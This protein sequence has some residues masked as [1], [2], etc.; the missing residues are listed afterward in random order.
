MPK[1]GRTGQETPSQ[2]TTL[3]RCRSPGAVRPVYTV[4]N[5]PFKPINKLDCSLPA[6]AEPPP[7]SLAQQAM[8]EGQAELSD[9]QG[10][11]LCSACDHHQLRSVLLPLQSRFSGLCPPRQ[12]LCRSI[13][14]PLQADKQPTDQ[15]SLLNHKEVDSPEPTPFSGSL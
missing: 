7:S 2:P 15:V 9:V 5:C 14:P 3:Q 12:P 10:T 6:S 8:T 13:T 1:K 11:H 4:T